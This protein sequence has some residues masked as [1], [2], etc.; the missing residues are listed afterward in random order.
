M[1]RGTRVVSMDITLFVINERVNTYWMKWCTIVVPAIHVC[2]SENN[3]IYLKFPYTVP[4]ERNV[5]LKLPY[6]R[7]YRKINPSIRR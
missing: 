7:V 4:N 6:E 3:V 2:V 5:L 1:G